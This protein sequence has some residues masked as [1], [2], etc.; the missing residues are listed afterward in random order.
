MDKKVYYGEYTLKY[1]IELLLKKDLELPDY[2]RSFVWS[3]E[4][5][6]GFVKG[7][8]EDG[9]V[10]PVTIGVCNIGGENHNL[11]LDG[12]QRLSSL[13][14]AYFKAF[15]KK[16]VFPR[17]GEDLSLADGAAEEEDGEPDVEYINWSLRMFADKGPVEQN[18]RDYITATQYN[19]VDYGVT[20]DFFETKFIPFSFIIPN[21]A[22]EAEQHEFYSTVFRNINI[23]GTPL[24]PIESRKSLYFLKSELKDF[25]D[26]ECCRGYKIELVGKNQMFDFVRAMALLSQF[27]K[28][29]RSNRLAQSYKPRMEKYYE[30][31]IYSVVKDSPDSMFAQFSTYIPNKDFA[32]RIVKLQ[33]S[34]QGLHYDQLHFTSIIDADVYM[35]GLIYQTVIRGKDIDLTR[36]AE[37]KSALQRKINVYKADQSHKG[38]P[39][40]FK[41]MR[42]RVEYSITTFNRYAL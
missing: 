41:H 12:Q 8:Q 35:L 16:D 39:S 33:R 40:L 32:P 18:V 23:L 14:L 5:V 21:A 37:L 13:L 22:D 3:E 34:L 29:G 9:F 4:Q 2:Q 24:E 10:P 19:H 20:P 17:G 25:F 11:I 1:W 6:K 42:S 36:G 38:S 31:Y 28:E 7:I 15:P 26:P 30:E 27:R